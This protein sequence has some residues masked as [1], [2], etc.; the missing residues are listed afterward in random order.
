MRDAT[1]LFPAN[2]ATPTRRP[3][4]PGLLP[5]VRFTEE[6]RLLL[7]RASRDRDENTA[8][9]AARPSRLSPCVRQ[10]RRRAGKELSRA[11]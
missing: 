6:L 1:R 9:R 4:T 3:P 2:V 10:A 5:F 7:P 8:A 11:H